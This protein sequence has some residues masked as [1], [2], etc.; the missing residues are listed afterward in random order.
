M[1]SNIHPE[2]RLQKAMLAFEREQV[3]LKLRPTLPCDVNRPKHVAE[4]QYELKKRRDQV[5]ARLLDVMYDGEAVDGITIAERADMNTSSCVNF[6][7]LM[8]KD[9]FICKIPQVNRT[10]RWI[11]I[12]TGKEVEH[13]QS[14]SDLQTLGE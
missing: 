5:F 12:K 14:E 7:N 10:I 6:L 4:R 8:A 13:G 3:K 9:G 2:E 11:Y 1:N